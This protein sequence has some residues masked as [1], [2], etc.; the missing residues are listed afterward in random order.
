MKSEGNGWGW[1]VVR[2]CRTAPEIKQCHIVR[3]CN[4]S[5]AATATLG[6]AKKEGKAKQ[7][8]TVPYRTLQCSTVVQRSNV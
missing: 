1:L 3:A 7:S 5:L 8:N 2:G 6:G 4:L